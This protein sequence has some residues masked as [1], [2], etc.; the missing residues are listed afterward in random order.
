M[1]AS[2]LPHSLEERSPGLRSVSAC[3]DQGLANH[4]RK[5]WRQGLGKCLGRALC[6]SSREGLPDAWSSTLAGHGRRAR[7]PLPPRLPPP[8]LHP[9]YVRKTCLPTSYA[10]S[11]TLLFIMSFSRKGNRAIVKLV[12]LICSPRRQLVLGESLSPGLPACTIFPDT[13]SLLHCTERSVCR[14]KEARNQI[15]K[16]HRCSWKQLQPTENCRVSEAKLRPR[17]PCGRHRL[18]WPLRIS[19]E[20]S[21]AALLSASL[22]PGLQEG[23]CYSGRTHRRWSLHAY[24]DGPSQRM[25]HPS[26][27]LFI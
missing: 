15:T 3:T 19:H 21:V 17:A 5:K 20:R 8:P 16:R 27:A 11:L 24:L 10:P 14:R 26:S 22:R 23:F 7:F 13:L 6:E 1:L 4:L 9:F 18:S 12:H 25:Q 2:H